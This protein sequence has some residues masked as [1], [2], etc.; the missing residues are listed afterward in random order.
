VIDQRGATIPAVEPQDLAPVKAP[1]RLPDRAG[2]A[3][4]PS[5]LL[6]RGSMGN[7]DV[8]LVELDGAP[9][10]VKDFAPRPAWVRATWGRFVTAREARAWER[11]D[12]HPAVPPFLGRI[13]GLAFAVAYRPGRAL[14]TRRG[15]PPDFV[16]RLARALDEMHARGVVHLDLSHRSNVLLGEGGAPVLIDFGSAVAFRPGGLG[17]RWLLPLLALLDRRALRKWERKLGSGAA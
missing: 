11:L 9:V 13:D 1:P 5:R 3:R 15:A 12:G 2:L 7:P 10:V 16:P 17:A 14:S 6:N 4:L 8:S